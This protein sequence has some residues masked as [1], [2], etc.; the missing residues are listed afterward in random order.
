MYFT[1]PNCYC[2]VAGECANMKAKVGYV[3]SFI[4][5]EVEERGRGRV[6]EEKMVERRKG[7]REEVGELIIF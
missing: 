4:H 5:E 2:W 6:G 1:D 7:K 3:N